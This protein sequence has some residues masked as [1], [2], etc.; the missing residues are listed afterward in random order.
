MISQKRKQPG[1]ST[2]A[3]SQKRARFAA[4]I[5]EPSASSRAAN[6]NGT[7]NSAGDD[8]DGDLDL[9]EQDRKRTQQGRKGRVV[10]EGYDSDESAQLAEDDEDIEDDDDEEDAAK[11]GG[12]DDD[13]MFAMDDG[14]DADGEGKPNKKKKKGDRFLKSSEIEG[15]EFGETTKVGDEDVADVLS[16]EDERDLDLELEEE[17]DDDED[18]D[19]LEDD[20][21]GRAERTPS[22]SLGGPSDKPVQDEDPEAKRRR[23]ARRAKAKKGMGH[24]LDSFN[25]RAE[26]Q[27]GRFDEDGNYVANSTDPHAQHDSWL[28]GNYSRKKIRAARDAQKK[29]EEEASAR[30]KASRSASG[31]SK[32]GVGGTGAVTEVECT[33]ALLD[34]MDRGESVLETLQRLGK[35]AQPH[36][37][38]QKTKSL[39]SG[40]VRKG[41]KYAGKGDAKRRALALDTETAEP[42]SEA[43]DQPKEMDVDP[44]TNDS[45]TKTIES[46]PSVGTAANCSASKSSE[47]HPSIVALEQYTALSS[48]LMSTFGHI[49]IYDET[50]ESILRLLRRKGAVPADWDPAAKREQVKEPGPSTAQSGSTVATDQQDL[51]QFTYRWAPAYLAATQGANAAPDVETYGPFPVADLRSWAASGYFGAPGQCERILLKGHS[52]DG[53]GRWKSWSDCGL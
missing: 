28:D 5:S 46:D 4:G 21:N 1:S 13:D 35:T 30:H 31:E 12:D 7:A 38:D 15:Q 47:A 6:G 25:M 42:T 40:S 34:F 22:P 39:P 37:A 26:F 14:D 51:R 36:A 10:T 53:E 24:K 17:N 49:N 44:T 41:G 11:N 29:R 9:D 2:A 52:E 48:E 18:H 20:Y 45:A 3:A 33:V 23:E 16:D 27:S 50:Y 43:D 19:S 32:G 8:N